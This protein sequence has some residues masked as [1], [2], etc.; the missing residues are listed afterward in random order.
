MGLPVAM[1]LPC[2]GCQAPLTFGDHFQ[3]KKVRCKKCGHIFIV[4]EEM[5]AVLLDEEE[6]SELPEQIQPQ[7]RS[8][9]CS[10]EPEEV[11][12]LPRP[13]PSLRRNRWGLLFGLGMTGMTLFLL[14]IAVVLGA[15]YFFPSWNGSL[16]FLDSDFRG[17]WPEPNPPAGFGVNLPEDTIVTL[18][19]AEVVNEET[20]DMVYHKAA[21]L[22]DGGRTNIE[23]GQ[24]GDRMTLRLGPVRDPQAC[25]SRID[26]GKVRRVHGRV[27]SVVAHPIEGL[28]PDADSLT[29][30]LHELKSPNSMRRMQAARRLKAMEPNE[31]REEVARDLEAYLDDPEFFMQQEI[32]EALS[33]WGTKK[34]VPALLQALSTDNPFTRQAIFHCLAHYPDEQVC[35]VLAKHLEKDM[36]RH[37][38]AAALKTIG[39]MAEKAVLKRLH[40]P[41]VFLRQEVCKILATIGTKESLPA[42]KQVVAEGEFFTKDEGQ[43][44]IEAIQARQKAAK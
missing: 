44:A 43:R 14:G 34:S 41:E 17:S 5:E 42:L 7:P 32:L 39:P 12:S 29:K 25:A 35:E 9:R 28:P 2:P 38:A 26:F 13:L 27:I 40:H 33:V 6:P 20:S 3:G 30:T 15:W 22:A 4:A 18:H 36:D 11:S 10:A 21:K 31:R 8:V 23:S 19:I 1:T 16:D 24:L 37:E